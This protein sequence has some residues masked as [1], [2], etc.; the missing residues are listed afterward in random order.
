MKRCVFLSLL[1]W[2]C[3]VVNADDLPRRRDD[4]KSTNNESNEKSLSI[5]ADDFERS[6][7]TL[8]WSFQWTPDQVVDLP[9]RPEGSNGYGLQVGGT[10]GYDSA[11]IQNVTTTD[12]VVEATV[13]CLVDGQDD[14]SEMGVFARAKN[15]QF[16]YKRNCC[17]ALSVDSKNG[18]VRAFRR[19]G[20]YEWPLAFEV[21]ENSPYRQ[22]KTGWHSL[23]ISAIGKAINA[24]IDNVLVCSAITDV[25]LGNKCVGVFNRDPDKNKTR[26]N[27]TLVDSFRVTLAGSEMRN[28]QTLKRLFYIR[29]REQDLLVRAGLVNEARLIMFNLWNLIKEM[30]SYRDDFQAVDE[31]SN[32]FLSWCIDIELPEQYASHIKQLTDEGKSLAEA[33]LDLGIPNIDPLA[34]KFPSFEGFGHV[35]TTSAFTSFQ[36]PFLEAYRL[37]CIDLDESQKKRRSSEEISRISNVLDELKWSFKRQIRLLAQKHKGFPSG[38]TSLHILFKAADFSKEMTFP[39]LAFGCYESAA[40]SPNQEDQLQALTRCA[41]YATYLGNH[42]CAAKYYERLSTLPGQK[43]ERLQANYWKWIGALEGSFQYSEAVNVCNVLS[44]RWPEAECAPQAELKGL[45]LLYEIQAYSEMV[46]MATRLLSRTQTNEIRNSA[47]ML[48]GLANMDMG[49]YRSASSL[50]SQIQSQRDPSHAVCQSVFAEAICAIME[51][52]NEQAVKLLGT[53]SESRPDMEDCCRKLSI[54]LHRAN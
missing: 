19:K 34:Q 44:S 48:L 53:L 27:Y 49:N 7:T 47:K 18:E 6:R 8:P 2:I 22:I 9:E 23:K 30:N 16:H 24:Y 46:E 52:R 40:H 15:G 25:C 1:L 35:G 54:L 29:Q 33:F 41:D 20:G 38:R 45:E 17:F 43:A 37:L 5:L 39:D 51:G 36:T 13:F 32:S 11:F 26:K 10:P 3:Y 50:F 42:A 28:L 12:H 31:I 14:H 4:K 21:P